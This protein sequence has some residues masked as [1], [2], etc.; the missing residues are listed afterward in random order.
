V[1][2]VGITRCF[3]L[4]G[5]GRIS[6]EEARLHAETEWEKYRIVQDRLFQSDFDV[7]LALEQETQKI[8]DRR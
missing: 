2:L 3:I 8:E 5:P 1:R 6:H 4:V 7:F